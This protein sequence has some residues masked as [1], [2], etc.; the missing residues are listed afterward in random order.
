VLNNAGITEQHE[1]IQIF[2]NPTSTNI[3]IKVNSPFNYNLLS[4]EGKSISQ[5][6]IVKETTLDLSE[7]SHGIYFIKLN[8]ES[9]IHEFKISKIE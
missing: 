6:H 2:P 4:S 8:N 1:L 5:G 7:L 9:E 3:V